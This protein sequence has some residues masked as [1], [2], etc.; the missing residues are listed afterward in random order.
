MSLVWTVAQ[1]A[2]K[3]N[4]FRQLVKQT[5]LVKASTM[6]QI[7]VA[8]SKLRCKCVK[9]LF[10]RFRELSFQKFDLTYPSFS[11]LSCLLDSCSIITLLQKS[12]KQNNGFKCKLYELNSKILASSPKKL[13]SFENHSLGNS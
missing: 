13:A 3:Q 4:L 9:W 10:F 8:W 6:Y 1:T 7:K 11:C 12:Q 5:L 2:L